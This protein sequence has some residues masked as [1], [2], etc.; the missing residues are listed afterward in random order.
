MLVWNAYKTKVRCLAFSP[1]GA[2]L[3]SSAERASSVRLWEP[4]TGRKLGELRG[5][6]GFVSG[7]SYSPDGTLLATTT[8]DYRV[9]VWDVAKREA[10]SAP[11]HLDMRYGPAFAPDE[12]CVAA[13]GQDGV[14]LWRDPATPH[15]E[16]LSLYNGESWEPD[17]QFKYD[18]KDYLAHTFDSLAFSPNGRLL[19]AQGLYVVVIW[20]CKTRKAQR[21][22][23]HS[24]ETEFRSVLAFSPN[25]ERLALGF[26]RNAEIHPVSGK[27]KV[28]KLAGHA[29]FV[30]AVGFTPDGR[31][32]MTAAGD[33]AV[34]FWDAATGKQLRAFDWGIGK[35]YSAAFAP[36]GLTCAAGGENGQVVVWDVDL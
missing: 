7:M 2:Q 28:V 34:R 18:G 5:R 17:E 10:L 20:N 21:V 31:T 22:I 36:D 6:W 19:A 26:E 8:M 14:A 12:S 23:K 11:E 3:A 25:G 32:A 15:P 33:G 27:G 30:R 16:T 1:D 13:G 24:L 35:L 4:T 29:G 9:V